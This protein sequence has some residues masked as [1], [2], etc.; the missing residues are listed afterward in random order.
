M[1]INEII[2][3]AKIDL[4][5]LIN[6]KFGTSLQSLTDYFRD[7]VTYYIA[8]NNDQVKARLIYLLRKI[9]REITIIVSDSMWQD[10]IDDRDVEETFDDFV[11]LN[12]EIEDYLETL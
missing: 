5:Q 9:Q 6:A 2:F 12:N 4:T 1:R 7:S 3:E 10:N 11:L 8:N